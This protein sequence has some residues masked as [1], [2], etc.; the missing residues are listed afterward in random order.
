MT[1]LS[2]IFAGIRIGCS[3][4]L[5]LSACLAV[6]LPVFA[7]QPLKTLLVGVDHRSV[8]SLNGDWHYLVD[9]P[10]AR[11]LYAQGK[12]RDNGYALNTH[13]NISS[14]PHNEEYD[15]ATAPTLKVPGDWNTQDPTLFRFEGVVWY[16]RDFDFQ[17]R[18][19]TRTFLHIGA[20]NYKSFVWV[21]QKRIC[22]HEGGFTPFDCEVTAAL[23]PG[24][25]F[26]VI[27]V[28]STRAG[29]WHSIGRY[30]L[31]QLRRA[32]PRCLAGHGSHAVH[33]RL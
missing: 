24:S 5:V 30:R 2:K 32:H 16:Q 15:F 13:P 21:N 26:V 22:D 9:Q 25:N 7:Q 6:A 12:V 31:V 27:A 20:A 17:P 11:G 10:P 8:T 14:G 4:G 1:F 28:D 3:N 19:N 29:R 18:A 23:K 33:R